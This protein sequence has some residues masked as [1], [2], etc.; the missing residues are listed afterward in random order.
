MSD[1]TVSRRRTETRQRLMEAAL[2]VFADRG[3]LA[4]SVEEICERAGFTR[5][6]FYSNFESKNDLVL[7]VLRQEAEQSH[8]VVN[9][10]AQSDLLRE[11][12][13]QPESLATYAE[14]SIRT[15][16]PKRREDR[17][18]VMAVAE[19]RLYAAREPEIRGAY[20]EFRQQNKDGLLHKIKAV[21]NASGW[22][23][24]I[25]DGSVIEVLDALYE[26]AVLNVMMLDPDGSRPDLTE[27]ALASYA[28]VLT[29]II[30]PVTRPEPQPDPLA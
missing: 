8:D 19:I 16:I 2:G 10:M 20:L 11:A 14:R 15:I 25:P 17:E 6:A 27:G 1:L 22:E 5:G 26:R 24:I 7:A 28:D 13:E 3:V 23:F 29:A 4:S 18:W 21:A 30:G 9:Q 12:A